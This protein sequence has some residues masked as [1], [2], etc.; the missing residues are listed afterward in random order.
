MYRDVLKYKIT[1]CGCFTKY[2]ISLLLLLVFAINARGYTSCEIHGNLLLYH[3]HIS[4]TWTAGVTTNL[5]TS[6]LNFVLVQYIDAKV[7]GNILF[8]LTELA[9][10][11]CTSQA[12]I[13]S[14]R[15]ELPYFPPTHFLGL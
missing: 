13:F 6:R 10:I 11:L 15:P 14:G 12:F 8:V 7:N 9:C 2:C 1:S 4:T 3:I 5:Q